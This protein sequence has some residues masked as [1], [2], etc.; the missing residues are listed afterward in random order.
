MRHIIRDFR[1]AHCDIPIRHAVISVVC[2]AAFFLTGIFT[3]EKTFI[4]GIAISVFLAAMTVWSTVEVLA[5][6]PASFRRFVSALPVEEQREITEG[7]ASS[8]KL[9]SRRF[10]E[11]NMFLLY[12]RNKIFVM[13]YSDII[14]GD[15]AGNKIL[16]TLADGRKIS[17]P[18]ALGENAPIIMAALRSRNPD[19]AIL[20]NGKK[21]DS[22]GKE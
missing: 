12:S 9:G 14:S 20:L 13:K 2:I 19:I 1:I 21:P 8:L 5:V 17:T 6:S 10:Y 18:I 3:N 22:T 15:F 7:Y 11:E 16:L 4:A